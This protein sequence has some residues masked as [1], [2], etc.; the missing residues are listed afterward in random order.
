MSNQAVPDF[1]IEKKGDASG[2]CC[3]KGIVSFK[4]LAS[5]IRSLPYCRTS[6]P[7]QITLVLE[8]GCGT[9]S[10]KHAFLAQVAMECDY[11]IQL[12]MGI[13]EM[14]EE[15]TPGVGSVIKAAKLSCIPEAHCYLMGDSMRL[16]LTRPENPILPKLEFLKEE[17][18]QPNEAA[19]VKTEKHKLFLKKWIIAEKISITFDE[20]WAIRERCIA[21]LCRI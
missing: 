1:A 14:N 17:A 18:L 8:E 20:L 3:A 19:R 15:N 21:N 11:P 13:Y 4:E 5:T 16:D 2:L 6:D 9:C 10:S 7:G 12:M